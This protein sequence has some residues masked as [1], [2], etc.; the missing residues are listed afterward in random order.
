MDGV[1]KKSMRTG[2]SFG[3]TSGVITTLGLMMGLHASTGSRA[4]LVGG[5][6][7]IAIADALSDA[8]GIHISEE[9]RNSNSERGIWAA[10]V[11][12]FLAKFCMAMS[13]LALVLLLDPDPAMMVSLLW[14]A[15]VI[16]AL[17]YLIA[18][19]QGAPAWKVIGEHLVIALLVVV[20]TFAVGRWI[21]RVFS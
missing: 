10:T 5:I 7:T 1:I 14:G 11:T 4:A 13:F 2:L 8:L 21:G 12:T 19:E 6:I 3:L 17:S 18:R 9:S 15:G 16:C 20:L